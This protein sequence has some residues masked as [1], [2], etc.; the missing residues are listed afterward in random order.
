M[1]AVF[2]SDVGASCV[3]MEGVWCGVVQVAW[4]AIENI[5]NNCFAMIKVL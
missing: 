2:G 1:C 5:L 4:L 3:G